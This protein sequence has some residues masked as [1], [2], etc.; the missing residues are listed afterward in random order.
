MQIQVE[1]PAC[2]HASMDL[3]K[4]ALKLAPLGPAE[5][6]ADALEVLSES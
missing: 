3:L 1:Q 6:V 4:I 2:V 5:S